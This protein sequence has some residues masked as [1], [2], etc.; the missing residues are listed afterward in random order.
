MDHVRTLQRRRCIEESKRHSGR[1]HRISNGTLSLEGSRTSL[2]S[3]NVLN[4]CH[5]DAHPTFDPFLEFFGKYRY[6]KTVN[7]STGQAAN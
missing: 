4:I 5:R 6:S 7:I 3:F 2:F 1:V